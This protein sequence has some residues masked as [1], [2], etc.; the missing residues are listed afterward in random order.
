MKYMGSKNRIA[1]DI[2]PIIL[3]GRTDQTYVE[4]F[5]GGCNLIDKVQGRR[6]GADINSDL[7]GMWKALQAGWLPPKNV[8]EFEYYAARQS[9]D[10]PLKTYISI[11]LSYSGKIWGGYARDGKGKRN[12]GEEAF[13]NVTKQILFIKGVEFVACSYEDLSIPDD[14]IIYCDPPYKGTTKY[15][16]SLDYE[17]FYHWCRIQKAN[18]H[19]IFISEYSM[20]IDFKCVWEKELVSSLTQDT[21]S[22]KAVERLFTL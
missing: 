9:A 17:A 6:I 12:Y 14:S 21:G 18:G 22:K 19:S 2:L 5:V 8:S 11:N 7:I 3:K 20:P 10:I 16:H 15:K 4:P 13:K 1:K